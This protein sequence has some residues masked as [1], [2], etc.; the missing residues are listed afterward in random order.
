MR[1]AQATAQ[2]SSPPLAFAT[3]PMSADV[4]NDCAQSGA[5]PAAF[6][7]VASI[8]VASSSTAQK[9][10]MYKAFIVISDWSGI[11]SLIAG[12][13]LMNS[14]FQPADYRSE[15]RLHRKFSS[16]C[17]LRGVDA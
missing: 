12:P 8:A 7:V 16:S 6:A 11:S 3:T 10:R 9:N 5:G 1:I 4:I 17:R 13:L 2:I 15:V 14:R